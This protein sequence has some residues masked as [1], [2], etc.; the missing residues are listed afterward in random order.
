MPVVF[1]P[2][3][4][5]QLVGHLASAVSGSAVYRGM[6]FLCATGS[7]RSSGPEMLRI[8]DDPL[9]A[10][11]SPRGGSTPKGSPVGE[12]SSWTGGV[13]K[14]F[15]LDTYSSRKLGQRSTASAVRSLGEPPMAGIDAISILEPRLPS[16]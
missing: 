13:L 4:A 1:D 2:E 3:T 7:E 16:A 15:L 12:T 6:S 5:R 10:E 8:V 9:R 14:T 11:D